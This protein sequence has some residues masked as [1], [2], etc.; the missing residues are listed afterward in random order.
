MIIMSKKFFICSTQF[1]QLQNELMQLKTLLLWLSATAADIVIA[2]A[3]SFLQAHL[4]QL[5]HIPHK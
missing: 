5:P 2:I 4:Y 1:K 3:S